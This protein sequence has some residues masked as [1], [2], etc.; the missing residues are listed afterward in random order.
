[1]DRPSISS[2]TEF[3]AGLEASWYRGSVHLGEKVR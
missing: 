1:M 3:K 2:D